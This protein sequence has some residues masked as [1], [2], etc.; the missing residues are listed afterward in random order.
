MDY[1]L[2]FSTFTDQL[3][4]LNLTPL[5]GLVA[6]VVYMLSKR[7][8]K[9]SAAAIIVMDI[10]NAE[11]V[12]QSIKERNSIDRSMKA[13]LHE[14]NW[15]KYKHLFANNLSYDDFLLLNKFFDS[16]E[17]IADARSR[18]KDIF[19]TSANRKASLMQEKI[20]AIENI[21]SIEGK[22]ERN[23]IVD[24]INTETIEFTPIDPIQRVR[25]SV[26][27]MGTLTNTL[28]FQKLKKYARIK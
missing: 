12:V 1:K 23:K 17:D 24:W 21:N 6:L 9:Q 2:L 10:R 7:H 15:T 28:V 18:M 19:Y 8:E 4:S 11:Q 26:D 25:Q 22:N 27:Q 3:S 14:N 13:I 5:I 20:F 16:C